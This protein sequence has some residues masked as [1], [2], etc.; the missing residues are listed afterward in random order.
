M[1]EFGYFSHTLCWQVYKIEHTNI[2]STKTN[3][4]SGMA[5]TEEL[6]DFQHGTIIGCHL[7]NKSVCQISVLLELPQSTVSAVI[8]KWKRLGATMAQ[9]RRDRPHKLKELDRRVLK[10]VKMFC[11]RLQH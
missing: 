11:P 2:Q 8:V 10:N 4:G 3:I 5:H 7:S 1:S 9:P 6:S